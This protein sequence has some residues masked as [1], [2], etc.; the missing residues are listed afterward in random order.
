MI[1]IFVAMGH[2]QKDVY[3]PQFVSGMFD[4]MSKTYGFANTVTSFGFTMRWRKQCINDLPAVKGCALGYDMMSGM[5]ETWGDLQTK[6]DTES[7]IIALDISAEMNRK[8]RL[9]LQRLKHKNIQLMQANVLENSIP[10]NSADFV[11]SA[12]GLKTFTPQQQTQFAKEVARIL[13]PGGSFAMIEV[14]EPRPWLLRI[15][16]MFYLKQ[17]IPLIGWAFLKN[18]DDYR[19]LGYYCS[20]FKDCGYFYTQLKELGMTVNHKNYFFGCASGVYGR[21]AN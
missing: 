18:T 10:A 16:F 1:D 6:L 17:I 13:K 8:A 11:V 12:F 7:Q 19:M 15:L 2:R 20:H 9:H 5:G 4:R 3:D 14:S 21:K